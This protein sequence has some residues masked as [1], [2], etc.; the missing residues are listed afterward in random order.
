[1]KIQISISADYD[2]ETYRKW[3]SLVNMSAIQLQ[4]FMDTEEGKVAGLSKQKASALGI[5][6]GR[7]SAKWILKMKKTPVSE[8]TPTMWTWAKRQISFISRM[9]GNKGELYD[10]NKNKTRKHTSLL[11]WG[12]NPK[13]S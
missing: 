12:H 13:K 11:I 4:K 7:E 3:K 6:S 2:K 5:R 9:K 8:W 1:M 10:K